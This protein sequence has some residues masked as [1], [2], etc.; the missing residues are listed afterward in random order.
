VQGK[1]EVFYLRGILDD[2][3]GLKVKIQENLKFFFI[4]DIVTL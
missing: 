3:T 1:K 2:L 4:S